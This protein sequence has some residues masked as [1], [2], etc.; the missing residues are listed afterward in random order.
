MH[1]SHRKRQN[2]LISDF[3]ISRQHNTG[4]TTVAV[5]R[6]QQGETDAAMVDNSYGS[7]PW[8]APETFIVSSSKVRDVQ[9][10]YSACRSLFASLGVLSCLAIVTL[11]F[12]T[13]FCSSYYISGRA[14]PFHLTCMRLEL[15][16]GRSRRA[17]FP[18]R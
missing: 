15:L 13:P 5:S 12:C 18:S 14:T 2:L 11:Y 3:G 9:C 17:S 4:A 1:N 8:S 16:L 7:A 10:M 6:G